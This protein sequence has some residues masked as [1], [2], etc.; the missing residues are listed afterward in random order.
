[1]KHKLLLTGKQDRLIDGFFENM[2]DLFEVQT[3]SVR[4]SD[5]SSHMEYF[6]PDVLVYCMK[7]ESTETMRHICAMKERTGRKA[8]AIIVIGELAECDS[9]LA[10]TAGVAD[11]LLH[12]PLAMEEIREE[13]LHFLKR[14]NQEKEK[15][16]ERQRVEEARRQLAEEE[17]IQIDMQQD[18]RQA[19]LKSDGEHRPHILV[20]DDDV[21][22][23]KVLKEQL[24]D[25]Y[26]V[27]TAINGKLAFKF[28][29]NKRTDLI[30]LDYVMPEEDGRSILKKIHENPMTKDIPVIFLSGMSE[31]E[32][33]RE[34]LNEGP[35]GYIL[36]PIDRNVLLSTIHSVLH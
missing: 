31:Q 20:I 27:A 34:V 21:R 13:L 18:M 12:Q 9:F 30:L 32:K 11:I 26:D 14:M 36:K 3:S 7:E 10:K 23:L 8:V 19:G 28:L 33:I 1:M 22:M 25:K 35:Q 6:Q 5:L 16:K 24:K 2:L 4:Y 15:Q 29:E 17:K